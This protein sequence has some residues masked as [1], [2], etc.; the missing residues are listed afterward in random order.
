MIEYEVYKINSMIFSIVF[1]TK[2]LSFVVKFGQTFG[3]YF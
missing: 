3:L 1:V 2:A